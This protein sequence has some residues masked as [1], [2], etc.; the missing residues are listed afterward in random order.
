MISG[1]IGDDPE[2]LS[3]GASIAVVLAYVLVLSALG[4]RFVLQRDVNSIQA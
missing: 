4:G 1:V 3:R 2:A